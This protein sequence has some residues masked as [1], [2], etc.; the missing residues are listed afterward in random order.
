LTIVDVAVPTELMD[1]TIDENGQ[2]QQSKVCYW[3]RAWLDLERGGIPV[4][5]QFWRGADGKPFDERYRERPTRI[6]TTNKIEQLANGAWYPVHTVEEEFNVDPALPPLTAEQWEAAREGKMKWPLYVVY[7][8]FHWE[9][10]KI[11]VHDP[12]D[13][14]FFVLKFPKGQKY[15]DLD[16]GKVVGALESKPA[17][18][19]GEVAR[20]WTIARWH[21]G[22]DRKL[23]EFRGKVV[24]LDFWGL[25]CSACRAGTPA[26]V[27]LQERFQDA[28]VVFVSIHTAEGDAERL[29]ERIEDYASKAGWRYLSAIDAGTMIEDSATSHTYGCSGMP[30]QIVIGADGIVKYNSSASPPGMEGI[31]GKSCDEITPEDTEKISAFMAKYYR[32]A[33]EMWPLP[34]GTSEAESIATSN[35]VTTFYLGNAVDAALWEGE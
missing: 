6:M 23:E 11:D 21:D 17:I 27:A 16:A 10:D 18:K 34:E 20:P 28:P 15:M 5:M 2:P 24:V 25:W 32:T 3:Y 22:Q 19:A 9:C 30:T 29:A 26:L 31:F 12:G 1:S 8:R 4:V 14:E 13:E 33:G 7:R 35:R